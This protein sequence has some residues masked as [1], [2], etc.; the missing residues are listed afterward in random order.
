MIKLTKSKLKLTTIF[1]CLCHGMQKSSKKCVLLSA[2]RKPTHPSRSRDHNLLNTQR[3]G[4]L[5]RL[6]ATQSDGLDTRTTAHRGIM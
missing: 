2:N 4:E 6:F 3:S 1:T 5:S